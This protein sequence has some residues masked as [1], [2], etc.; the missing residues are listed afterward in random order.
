MAL[1]RR[2]TR[3]VAALVAAALL[4]AGAV[5]WQDPTRLIRLEFERQR[6]AAG[7]SRAEVVIDGTRWVYAYNGKAPADAPTVLMLHGFTGSKENWYPVAR[8]LRGDYRLLV[9][10]LPGWSQSER[11]ADADYGYLA[12]SARVARFIEQMTGGDRDLVL[13]GHSMGGGIAAVTAARYPGQVD[14]VGLLAASGVRFDDNGFGREVLDGQNPFAV[15]DAASL[16]R[17]LGLLFED[18]AARPAMPWPATS[19]YIGE[20]RRSAAFE[21]SVLDSIGRGTQR[22]LPGEAAAHINQPALLLWCEQDAVIDASALQLYAAQMP[23]AIGV[24]IGG[25]GHMSLMEQPDTVAA[26]V[27]ELIE[28]GRPR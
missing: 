10:D 13:L 24:L 4:L 23:Q 6:I 17:Y 26:A 9:P 11:D 19:I 16:E 7:L 15:T 22:F 1:R 14:R 12:Q 27:T 18:A 25:C 5:L 8:R 28:R 20:R 21:Q 3:I 2:R